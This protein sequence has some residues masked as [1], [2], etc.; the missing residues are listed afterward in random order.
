MVEQSLTAG[1][2]G[3][4]PPARVAPGRQVRWSSP[5]FQEALRNYSVRPILWS[6]R[7]AAREEL[8]AC[9]IG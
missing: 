3:Q 1:G 5:T 4:A 8:A 9:V 2:R 7:Q 6:Y